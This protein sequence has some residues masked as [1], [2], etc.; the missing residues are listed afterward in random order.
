MRLS[1]KKPVAPQLKLFLD[2][3]PLCRCLRTLVRDWCDHIRRIRAACGRLEALPAVQ[4][5]SL[6]LKGCGDGTLVPEMLY[7]WHVTAK[8]Q[9][10][11]GELL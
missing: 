2:M 9:Q 4:S 10:S 8:L 5:S 6:T 11:K 3:V 7:T 1:G